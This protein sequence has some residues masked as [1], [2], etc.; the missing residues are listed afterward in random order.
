MTNVVLREPVFHPALISCPVMLLAGRFICR[1]VMIVSRIL[2]L[3]TRLRKV[4]GSALL[5]LRPVISV[6]VEVT[7]LSKI[8]FRVV[9]VVRVLNVDHSLILCLVNSLLSIDSWKANI[10]CLWI[11]SKQRNG[12]VPS[13]VIPL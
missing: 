8:S 7:S 9:R 6:T 5:L 1:M 12:P 13:L 3:R 10:L 2:L 11:E 4:F